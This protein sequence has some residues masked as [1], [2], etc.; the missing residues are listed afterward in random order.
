MV[1]IS[2]KNEPLVAGL[3]KIEQQTD[4][5]FAYVDALLS[6]YQ[7]WNLPAGM[8]SLEE[9]LDLLLNN[10]PLVYRVNR[11]SIAILLRKKE[12]DS[13][14]TIRGRVFNEEGAALPGATVLI[15][16]A[17]RGTTSDTSGAFILEH[18]KLPAGIQVRMVGY[19]T[20]EVELKEKRSAPFNITLENDTRSLDQVVVVGYN[21]QK[22]RNIISSIATV[23][24]AE[25]QK[26]PT[27]NISNTLAGR[28]PGVLATTTSGRPGI[29][30]YFRIRGKVSLNEPGPLVVVDGIIRNDEYGNINP[31][32]VET[33]SVLK[34]AAATAVYGARAAGG[35]ILI[36]TKRGTADRPVLTYNGS[37]GMESPTRYPR[38]M[39]AYEY[40]AMWNQASLN[41]GYDPDN[42]VH[43]SRFY[44][45][46]QLQDFKSGKAGTDWWKTVLSEKGSLSQQHLS[47]RGGSE[48]VRFFGMLGSAYQRGLW[49]SYNFRRIN[50]RANID[51][52]IN[53][54][55]TTGL[56]LEARRS[57]TRAAGLDAYNIFEH[58][59]QSPPTVPAY[60]VS[61]R[62]YDAMIPHP[63]ADIR[64]SGENMQRDEVFQGTVFF[65][66]QLPFITQGLSIK[67]TAAM[68]RR[69]YF[70]KWWRTPYLLYREDGQG[71]ITGIR[72]IGI[73]NQIST[74]LF[75]ESRQF[76]NNTCNI[77][78]NYAKTAGKS[79]F[80]GLAL[81]EQIEQN[82]DYFNASRRQFPTNRQDYFYASGPDQ[83]TID[84]RSAIDDARRSLVGI[85]NFTY[86]NRYLMNATVRYDGS[87]R[88][89]PGRR[90]GLFPSVSAGWRLS[91]EPFLRNTSFFSDLKLRASA[92]I[93]GNDNVGA[94]QYLDEYFFSQGQV[95]GSF[96]PFYAPVL[97]NEAAIVL[98]NGVYANPDITWEKL[99]TANIGVDATV[100]QGRLDLNFDYYFRTTTDM[101][102]NRARSVPATFGRTLP[103][104]N[105]AEMKSNGWELVLHYTGHTRALQYELGVQGTFASNEITRIDDPVNGPS[106]EKRQGRP[107]GFQVGYRAV[108]IF[109]SETEVEKWYGGKQFGQKQAPGDIKYA[110]VNGDG[111]ITDQDQDVISPYDMLPEFIYGISGGL[112]WK[113]FDMDF[114]FQG[115]ARRSLMLSM[116]AITL[117][118]G[119][120]YNSFAYLLDAWSPE[121]KDAKYPRTTIDASFNN[122]RYSTFWLRDASY[123]RLKTVNIGYT[124][125]WPWLK[126]N[127]RKLRVYI[128]GTNLLTWSPFKEFDPEAENGVGYYYPQMK[129]FTAGTALSF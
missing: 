49:D 104:E 51:A 120:K 63:L 14:C 41:A 59:V 47:I 16:A 45:A 127:N 12:T 111:E 37:I 67:G 7:H 125:N 96:P 29:G 108:G 94:F 81:Y 2:L 119:G 82:S 32:E 101:L 27:L 128:A 129:N 26:T 18:V 43:A 3:Q 4:F 31:Y 21:A 93:T 97:D 64:E 62:Y 103:K 38:L 35:V 53:A 10:T 110:D 36:T 13:S 98:Y 83:Q 116:E 56:N 126:K 23:P 28:V 112:R 9:T 54:T 115:A 117:F 68:V 100:L 88:F 109:Q 8:R 34:D 50:L 1:T 5:R 52:R 79:E 84:G 60:T 91:E 122:N 55:L 71:N 39:N 95:P 75:E 78:L 46:Q 69:Q 118:R 17:G 48:H 25:I 57:I 114:L 74:S 92:G 123:L 77:S 70:Q 44:T 72:S 85:V 76:T 105:Y 80:S 106:W 65:E 19:V 87:Y 30:A 15:K 73:G 40:A 20:R 107:V 22:K 124:F 99:R 42:P 11:S 90:W 102:W 66:Q 89:P 113:G 86:N 24:G 61:G 58:T 6:P 121:N 33:I